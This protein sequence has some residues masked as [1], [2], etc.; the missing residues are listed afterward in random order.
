MPVYKIN[1]QL[2]QITMDAK[3]VAKRYKQNLVYNPYLPAGT[4]LWSGFDALTGEPVQSYDEISKIANYNYNHGNT[5][6]LS[7]PISKASGGIKIS[8]GMF[9]L[10]HTNS[11]YA[12]FPVFLDKG[13]TYFNTTDATGWATTD[14][15]TYHLSTETAGIP[16]ADATISRADAMA[17]KT[18]TLFDG[19]T[20]AGA[21]GGKVYGQVKGNVLTVTSELKN[22]LGSTNSSVMAYDTAGDSS[23]PYFPLFSSIVT[24]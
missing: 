21:L 8:F 16:I 11:K 9:T 3:D 24:Y 20:Y 10:G 2:S 14:T 17:G 4:K 13:G 18:V 15:V 7:Q 6:T 12:A 22:S 1:K 19:R 5:I 23:K